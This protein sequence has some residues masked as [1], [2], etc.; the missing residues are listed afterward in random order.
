MA[1]V[2]IRTLQQCKIDGQK[3]AALTAYD[4]TQAHW[5]QAAGVEVTLVGDSL[6]NVIQ[7]HD[8][9]LPV[10]LDDMVYHTAAV[11]RAQGNSFLISDVP[12]LGAATPERA[13]AATERLMQAGA[14]MVKLEGGGWLA[15]TVALLARN[16][17]PVCAHLGLTPQSVHKLGGYRVQGRDAAAAQLLADAD[18][19]VKAGADLLLVECI[20]ASLAAELTQ[21][22]AVPVIGI[23][24]GA[25]V[26]AQ[27]L[28]LY[29]M[30]GLN[31][32][33]AARFVRN[34][35]STADS[36]QGAILQYREAV[37]DGSFPGPEHTFS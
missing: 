23:G 27:V 31:P 10:T 29:D 11:H 4:A 37:L 17:I 36:P 20:P 33:P 1:K 12:F 19:L 32:K 22:S 18:T 35:M 13:L 5:V 28:V 14:E 6:G 3:F 8:S 16:G 24:A 21:R 7:G 30:L 34:F 25:E 15:E 9:T 26:D 2:T